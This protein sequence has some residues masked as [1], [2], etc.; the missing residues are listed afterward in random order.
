MKSALRFIK[1]AYLARRRLISWRVQRNLNPIKA[2]R[3]RTGGQNT[4]TPKLDATRIN[5]YRSPGIPVFSFILP[6]PSPY[7]FAI[8]RFAPPGLRSLHASNF[9]AVS[10]SLPQPF[11]IF[12]FSPGI[13]TP[14]GEKGSPAWRQNQG[15]ITANGR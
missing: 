4:H 9:H 5:H 8:M 12:H 1:Q 14:P 6:I 11:C 3:R 15:G 10:S 7:P 13:S 2:Y